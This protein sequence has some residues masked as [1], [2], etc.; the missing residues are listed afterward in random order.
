MDKCYIAGPITD[1]RY[2]IERF[3][4]AEEEVRAM[5]MIPVNPVTLPHQHDKAWESYM[6]EAI[7]AMMQCTHIYLLENWEKSKGAFIEYCLADDLKFKKI[8]QLK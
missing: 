1:T 7:A 3:A 6:K 4:Q 8:F 5:G 2:Y